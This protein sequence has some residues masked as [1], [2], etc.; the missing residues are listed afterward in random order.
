MGGELLGSGRRGQPKRTENLTVRLRGIECSL[1]W[2]FHHALIFQ[3][4]VY[5]FCFCVH[6]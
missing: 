2:N 5:I 4:H 1:L 3:E 6:R